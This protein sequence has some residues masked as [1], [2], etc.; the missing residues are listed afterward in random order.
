MNTD[1]GRQFTSDN[2]INC[3]LDC[4]VTMSMDGKGRWIDNVLIERFWRSIKY[5]DI[6]LKSYETPRELGKGIR[7]YILRYNTQRPHSSLSD[8]TPEELYYENEK[9]AA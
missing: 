9:K 4:D 1:Q 3:L 2:W 8:A 7:S 6:Y 5:E